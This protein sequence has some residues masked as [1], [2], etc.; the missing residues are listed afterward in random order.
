MTSGLESPSQATRGCRV[1]LLA[2]TELESE[3]LRA[4]FKHYKRRTLATKP[5]YV[6]EMPAHRER[7]L[8]AVLA[9]SGCDKV[10]AAMTLTA[11]LQ[12][13]EPPPALVLQVGIAGAFPPVGQASTPHLGDVVIATQEAYSDVGATSPQGW[14]P[15]KDLGLSIAEIAGVE[16]GGVFPCDPELVEWALESLRAAGLCLPTGEG[17]VPGVWAGP[18]VTSSTVTGI[19]REARLLQERWGAVAESMEGAA[20]AQVCALFGVPFLEVRAISNLVGDR[21]RS[22]WQI[23]RATG[24]AGWAAVALVDALLE[25]WEAG[26]V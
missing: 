7:G 6:G 9:V 15:A 16:S 14:I 3:V 20:A 23:E 24:V 5:I 11:V 4:S 21:E 22:G 19:D 8:R 26:N 17:G 25:R 2:A 12:A 1:V 13:L 18:F 10:N